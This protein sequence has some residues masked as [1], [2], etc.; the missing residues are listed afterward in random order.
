MRRF[1]FVELKSEKTTRKITN[2]IYMKRLNK[3][4][5]NDWPTLG[6]Y[7]RIKKTYPFYNKYQIIY[8]DSTEIWI[9]DFWETNDSRRQRRQRNIK[10]LVT[11]L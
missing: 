10:L 9:G 4:F 8:Y 2:P 6:K 5:H 7:Y 3:S 1:T 11:K